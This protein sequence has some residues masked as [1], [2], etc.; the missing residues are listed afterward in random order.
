MKVNNNIAFGLKRTIVRYTEPKKG[1]IEAPLGNS[2][3]TITSGRVF[4]GTKQRTHYDFTVMQAPPNVEKAETTVTGVPVYILVN[5][6]SPDRS[7]TF[8]ATITQSKRGIPVL[9]DIHTTQGKRH[10]RQFS[11]TTEGDIF[12]R[13]NRRLRDSEIKVNGHS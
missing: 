2:L 12:A 6:G 1:T 5:N 10:S 7:D 9:T 4:T 8:E 13:I 3:E 11:T